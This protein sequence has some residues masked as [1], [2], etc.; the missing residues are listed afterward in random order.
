MPVFVVLLESLA[1]MTQVGIA[2]VFNGEVLDNECK[3]YRVP[4]VAPEPRGGGC[5]VVAKFGIAVSEEV[6]S[7]DACLGETVHATAHFEVDPGVRG[8]LVEL[9]L[10]N[11][12]LGDVRKLDADILWPV[13]RGVEIEVLEVYGGKPRVMLGENT[14]DEQFDKFN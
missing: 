7:K 8:K 1:K 9:V 5:L 11:E 14:V 4:L 13:E 3:H 12:F 6:F 10:V 2:N